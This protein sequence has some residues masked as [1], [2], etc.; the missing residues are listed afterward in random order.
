MSEW[1][2]I[3]RPEDDGHT[4]VA[5]IYDAAEPGGYRY[6]KDEDGNVVEFDREQA[7][8]L[9]AGVNPADIIQPPP[10]LP[11]IVLARPASTHSTPPKPRGRPKKV[12][13][14]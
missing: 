10:P 9:Q 7:K 8:M 12:K 13:D 5:V 11:A 2:P 4:Y 6:F 14:G 1:K 3:S